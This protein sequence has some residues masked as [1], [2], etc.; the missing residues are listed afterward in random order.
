MKEIFQMGLDKAKILE[1]GLD[2][3]FVQ[4]QL[5][6]TF[7]LLDAIKQENGDYVYK[8]QEG[9]S[10]TVLGIMANVD[11]FKKYLNKYYYIQEC[12]G[13]IEGDDYMDALLEIIQD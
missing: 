3:A 6:K 11:N 13:H 4:E 7:E 1:D 5:D 2:F 10:F 8:G 12:G 9:I